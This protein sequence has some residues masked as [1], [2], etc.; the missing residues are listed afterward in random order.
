MT[1][2][3]R[4]CSDEFELTIFNVNSDF[5]VKKGSLG[6]KCPQFPLNSAICKLERIRKNIDYIISCNG[7]FTEKEFKEI[8]ANC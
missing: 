7:D 5:F 3:L 2:P 4:F 6:K 8:V 1:A